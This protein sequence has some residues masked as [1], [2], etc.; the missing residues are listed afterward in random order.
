MTIDAKLFMTLLVLLLATVAALSYHWTRRHSQSLAGLGL[1]RVDLTQSLA[2]APF[3]V[4]VIDRAGEIVLQNPAASRLLAREEVQKAFFADLAAHSE[5]AYRVMNVPLQSADPLPSL[6]W[7]R[8]RSDVGQLIVVQGREAQIERERA[9]QV[10]WGSISHEMRTPLTSLLSHL[11]VARSADTP[12]DLR[13]RSLTISQQQARRLSQ[14]IQDVLDLGRLQFRTPVERRALDI[15]LVAEEAV[16]TMIL[17]AEEAGIALSLQYDGG[18]LPVFGD[19]D[20][21]KQVFVNLIDN[22]INYARAGDEVAVT[23][24]EHEQGVCC[25]VRDTGVGISVEHLP[26]IT[27][28]FYRANRDKR[29]SGLGLAI[30][31]EILRQHDSKLEIESATE[32]A[33][34]GTKMRFLL[35][36][37]STL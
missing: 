29:G 12:S 3:G 30:V 33:L 5:L 13:E 25:T 31:S 35:P 21:L 1:D 34:R 6:S 4:V 11:D 19:E 22:A 8:T 36:V 26:R 2:V 15:I 24:L 32:G 23:L 10:Y 37:I 7:W 17:Q 20:R 28:R 14:L 9:M 16:A 18:L 27:E